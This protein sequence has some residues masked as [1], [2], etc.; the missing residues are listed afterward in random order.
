LEDE[1]PPARVYLGRGQIHCVRAPAEDLLFAIKP[2]GQGV[3]I[4]LSVTTLVFPMVV[5]WVNTD[6][7]QDMLLL[8]VKTT[9][10]PIVLTA[11]ETFVS[12]AFPEI[13]NEPPMVLRLFEDTVDWAT[14][15]AATEDPA[16]T[17]FCWVTFVMAAGAVP[18]TAW[19]IVTPLEERTVNPE[20]VTLLYIP[21]I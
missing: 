8:F 19:A 4:V 2:A 13:V 6:E 9:P 14:A 1:F 3:W 12:A 18:W 15:A 20:I 17:A 7:D 21:L 10:T 11:V 16:I 5:S